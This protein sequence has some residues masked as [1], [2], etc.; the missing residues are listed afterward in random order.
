MELSIGQVA[1]RTGA[2]S[3]MLRHYDTIGLFTPS[4]ISRNGYRWYDVA[5]LPRLYRIVALRRS[6]LGL[7]AISEVLTE[8]V[9]EAAALGD[10][11]V[12]LR[13]QQDRLGEL[14]SAIEDGIAGS[15]TPGSTTPSSSPSPTDAS[16]PPLPSASARS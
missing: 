16:V 15:A 5:L 1:Q 2:S 13:D 7:T 11:L 8:H 10:H 6:G 4:R 14:I 3:R 9:E 12:E